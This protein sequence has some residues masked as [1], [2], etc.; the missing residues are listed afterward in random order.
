MSRADLA[1]GTGLSRTTISS[2]VTDLIGSGEVVETADRG[3]PH[4]GGS[5]RPPLLV[6]LTTPRGVVA[7]VD[8]G[9]GHVRVAIAD[10]SGRRARR[11]HGPARRRRARDGRAR[12]RCPDGPRRARGGRGGAQRPA[13]RRH[14][15]A[16]PAGPPVGTDQHR[17]HA[18]L[19]A[20]LP[21][22]RAAPAAR[23]TGLRR[24]RRQPRRPRRARPRRRAWL[25]RRPLRQAG[26]RPG[27]RHRARRPAAPRRDRHRRRDRAR[28]G[29]RG[30]PGVPL[31]QPRLPGDRGRSTT[32][33]GTA[34]AGI[35]RGADRR[36]RPRARRRRRCRR[37]PGAQRCG[38]VGRPRARGP[39]QQP[40]PRGGRARRLA[41]ARHRRSPR[42]SAPRWTAMRSPTPLPPCGWSPASWATAPRWSGRSRSRSRG[43]AAG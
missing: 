19:A 17:D 43:V 5:G 3:R 31:R 18:G 39:L 33:A 35:R 9:H 26:Q 7:G 13:R 38:L 32:A 42:A 25:R 28:P 30:R 1:R 4:K 2:L 40:Q 37:T 8:I 41:R 16:G 10:R 29:R 12:P 11:G 6:A 36:E 15:R 23:R 20:P 34:P 24:Q 22:R 27:R 14:V 21:R